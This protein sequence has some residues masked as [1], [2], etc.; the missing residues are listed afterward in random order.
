MLFGLVK[1]C[2]LALK[3]FYQVSRPEREQLLQNGLAN[4]PVIPEWQQTLE[5]RNGLCFPIGS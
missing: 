2:T 4:S 5:S 3:L 1:I